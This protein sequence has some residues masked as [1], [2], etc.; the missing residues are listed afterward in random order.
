MFNL[1]IGLILGI[2]LTLAYVDPSKLSDGLHSLEDVTREQIDDQEI[3]IR[4]IMG[5]QRS[6]NTWSCW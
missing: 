6:S 3:I 5:E 4:P 1:L 2:V